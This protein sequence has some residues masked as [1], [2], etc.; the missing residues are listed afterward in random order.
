MY[1]FKAGIVDHKLEGY[2]RVEVTCVEA[3]EGQ[4]L[5]VF[6]NKR[7]Q[8]RREWITSNPVLVKNIQDNQISMEIDGVQCTYSCIEYFIT[9]I[10][11]TLLE[12]AKTFID[13]RRN[14]DQLVKRCSSSCKQNIEY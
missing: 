14:V 10:A 4:D 5:K 2:I 8:V 12:S 1:K 9:E 11:R 6:L 7:D 3:D 13:L